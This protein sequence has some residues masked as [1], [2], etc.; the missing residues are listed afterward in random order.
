[1]N[2]YKLSFASYS[3]NFLI[4]LFLRNNF[5]LHLFHF[6]LKFRL[7]FSSVKFF[8]KVLVYHPVVSVLI[9]KE[10]INVNNKIL[11]LNQKSDV[12]ETFIFY[13][14][15]LLIKLIIFKGCSSKNIFRESNEN[16]DLF[17]QWLF[18]LWNFYLRFKL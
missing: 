9:R 8:F 10:Y 18:Y 5:K 16:C 1:M 2:L 12:R 6:N 4:L 11:P 7:M 17:K 14:L 13:S 15:I 3:F